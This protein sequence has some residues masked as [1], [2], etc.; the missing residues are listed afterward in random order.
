MIHEGQSRDG[1]QSHGLHKLVCLR[2]EFQFH[3]CNDSILEVI[4]FALPYMA[5]PRISAVLSTRKFHQDNSNAFRNNNEEIKYGC[6]CQ[7]NFIVNS[8]YY[9]P[10]SPTNIF[11][12]LNAKSSF[13]DN[14]NLIDNIFKRNEY[15]IPS[16]SSWTTEQIVGST[17]PR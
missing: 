11:Q 10:P 13:D 1:L 2:T 15:V 8:F 4:T 17:R 6:N 5:L 14:N 9:P 16:S 3:F 12:N 7:V